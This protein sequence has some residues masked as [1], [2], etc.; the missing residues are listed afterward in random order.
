M[1]EAVVF[2]CFTKGGFKASLPVVT[3]EVSVVRKEGAASCC[4]ILLGKQQQDQC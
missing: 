1:L 4:A 2:K 3:S